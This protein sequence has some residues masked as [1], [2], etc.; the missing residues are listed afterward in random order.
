M[1]RTIRCTD[2]RKAGSSMGITTATATATY[3]C[4]SSAAVICWRR[5][6][7]ARTSTP[8]PERSRKWRSSL[9]RSAGAGHGCVVDGVVRGEPC[10]LPIRPGAQRASGRGDQGR[11]D[12]RDA[13][14]HPDRQA[15]A[16]L[17]GRHLV[18]NLERGVLAADTVMGFYWL[19]SACA[20]GC[21][22]S[23]SGNVCH[24]RSA[25]RSHSRHL[26]PARELSAAVSTRSVEHLPIHRVTRIPVEA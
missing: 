5:S 8:R 24:H 1:Q 15:G 17:Q 19:I 13:A 22:P 2:I 26:S 25:G 18:E 20:R 9:R 23:C 4:M 14:E 7:A 6:C 3:R 10:R 11:A 21:R 16:V 12:R